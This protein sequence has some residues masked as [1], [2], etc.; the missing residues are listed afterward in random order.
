MAEES[1]LNRVVSIISFYNRY[2]K[3]L[4][5]ETGLVNDL[6]LDSLDIVQLV[7]DIEQSFDLEISDGEITSKNFGSVADVCTLVAGK[8]DN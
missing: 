3:E 6:G 5:A 2:G 8:L 1:I 7:Q 4:R